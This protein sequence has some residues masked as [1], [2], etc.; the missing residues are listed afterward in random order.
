MIIE[1][2]AQSSFQESDKIYRI[3][4]E[5]EETILSEQEL[6]AIQTILLR[7]VTGFGVGECN[8]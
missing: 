6:Q 5:D 2:W 8:V 3:L 7:Q 1:Q 4:G